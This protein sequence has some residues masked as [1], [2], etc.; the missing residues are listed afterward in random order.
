MVNVNKIIK[1]LIFF[2]ITLYIYYVYYDN[3][4][5]K[6]WGDRKTYELHLKNIQQDGKTYTGIIVGGSNS[7]WG[8]SA[9]LLTENTNL[10]YYNLSILHEGR[11]SFTHEKFMQQVSNNYFDKNK[12][13]Q[14][15]YSSITPFHQSLFKSYNSE[16]ITTSVW[17]VH[18]VGVKPFTSY[19]QY[20]KERHYYK[21]KTPDWYH[22]VN[23]NGDLN[24]A[25]QPCPAEQY[26]YYYEMADA[27]A[28]AK[29]FNK[30]ANFLSE[31]FPNAEV[32]VLTPSEYIF[33]NRYP[34]EWA[35]TIVERFQK[36]AK[37]NQ[38]I[39]VQAQIPSF[40][41]MCE[42]LHHPNDKG[43]TWRTQQLV[44]SLQTKKA[45]SF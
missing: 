32:T 39:V 29:F 44:S 37:S 22:M 3:E 43:R 36:N 13:E 38:R 41:L 27:I 40:S 25:N 28:V 33:M 7:F 8:L 18:N 42:G 2:V 30:K 35:A 23:N 15:I 14:V 10:K 34:R 31:Q 17:G 6:S 16:G 26:H 20:L 1:F 9:K 45:I 19:Y 12:I 21:Q 4:R 24:F 5:N 11:N